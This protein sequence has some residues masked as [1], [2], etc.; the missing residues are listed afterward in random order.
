MKIFFYFN[1]WL[2]QH[3]L[4]IAFTTSTFQK[5][6]R[7]A[8]INML[9]FVF[10][11]PEQPKPRCVL[12]TEKGCCSNY[13]LLFGRE[14]DSE[15]FMTTKRES[16]FVR[17]SERTV[18][19]SVWKYFPLF[20]SPVMKT[21]EKSHIT[22]AYGYKSSPKGFSH[23]NTSSIYDVR[24]YIMVFASPAFGYSSVTFKIVTHLVFLN[25]KIN[26]KIIVHPYLGLMSSSYPNKILQIYLL[27]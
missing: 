25:F 23:A 18:A 20:L 24:R 27:K 2:Q 26:S 11:V 14:V 6:L 19:L 12:Q 21:V 4:T 3:S 15:Y 13:K 8:R 5:L 17:V 7:C 16:E 1:V 10:Y 22:W 9:P